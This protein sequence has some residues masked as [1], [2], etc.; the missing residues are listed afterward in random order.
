[1]TL[2]QTAIDFTLNLS[3]HCH[4][5]SLITALPHQYPFAE[6]DMGLSISLE[7]LTSDINFDSSY[8]K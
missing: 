3:Q 4:W 6:L 5:S 1:M 8:V 2:E 7:R